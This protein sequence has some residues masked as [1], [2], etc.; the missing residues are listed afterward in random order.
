MSDQINDG[1][2]AFPHMMAQGH[3]DYAGGISLRDYF[4]GQI[5]SG[6]AAFSG[7]AGVS[8][9]PDEIAGRSYQVADAM[10]KAREASL[11]S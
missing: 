2:P 5:A 11:C 9:G 6:M 3:P 10:L 4:A 8:Y 7:T 1:G